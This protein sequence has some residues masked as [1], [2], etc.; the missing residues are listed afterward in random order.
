MSSEE[1][2][3]VRLV[4]WFL[5]PLK[6]VEISEGLRDL[7]K[8]DLGE[9][10]YVDVEVPAGLLQELRDLAE[11][12]FWGLNQVTQRQEIKAAHITRV[13]IEAKLRRL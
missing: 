10:S 13:L 12:Q 9:R 2:V 7:L 1:S 11:R 5:D 8:V 6:A 3:N 4:R